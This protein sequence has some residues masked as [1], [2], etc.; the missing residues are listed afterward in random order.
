MAS[1]NCSFYS[2]ILEKE[3]QAFVFL[4]SCTFKDRED[5]AEKRFST[6]RKFKTFVLLHG[7]SGNFSSWQ[8]NTRLEY[9][10]E[11]KEVAVICP[12]GN[13]GHYTD[14]ETGPQNLT[15]LNDEFLPA[16]QAM[17]PLSKKMEDN[18]I[19]G[20]SM[21]GYG[22]AKWAFTYPGVFSNLV[23][24]S[25]G[26]NI[27]PRIEYYKQKIGLEQTKAIFGNLDDSENS[28]HNIFRLMTESRDKN[29]PALRIYSCSGTEDIPASKAHDVFVKKAVEYGHDVTVFKGPGEHDFDFWDQELKKV[30]YEWLP[31]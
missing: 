19:G 20:Y 8:R 29:D 25:G 24:F 14:W 11:Q 27:I 7:F 21:G 1:F 22:A 30:I 23:S 3:V 4:P 28:R 2:E 13:N 26:L 6:E 12:D 10:A 31:L 17:F 15:H 9:Y 18:F 5:P 16:M